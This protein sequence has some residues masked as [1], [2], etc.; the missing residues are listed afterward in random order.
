VVRRGIGDHALR[1]ADRLAAP[2]RYWPLKIGV[3]VTAAS[4]LHAIPA[5]DVVFDENGLRAKS[6]HLLSHLG[7]DGPESHAAKLDFRL[8]APALVRPFDASPV[9][10]AVLY[11]LCGVVAY[12]LMAS[13]LRRA[14]VAPSAVLLSLGAVAATA[15]GGVFLI[16]PRF[17]DGL[18]IALA[19][20]AG[21]VANR[22]FAAA[23]A[24]V[25][26]YTDERA[27]LA[28]LVCV[29]AFRWLDA[30]SD[31]PP[32][33][34]L[35]PLALLG[36][37]V[38]YAASRL[39]LDAATALRTETADVGF[40]VVTENLTRWPVALV[41]AFALAWPILVVGLALATQRDL[42]RGAVVV[43]LVGAVIAASTLVHDVTRSA[44]YALPA[45]PVAVL[46]I[47]RR[48][49]ERAVAKAFGLAFVACM[50]VPAFAMAGQIQR[51][52]PLPVQILRWFGVL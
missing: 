48:W 14:K 43:A 13:E 30:R 8:V 50:L 47:A 37:A 23:L 26:L 42:V 46:A 17:F 28:L 29:A 12:A 3:L 15:A 10:A 7:A 35:S 44:A 39:V 4:A 40:G 52:N 34:G 24:F 6:L 20:A 41:A 11:A 22:W 45:V 2:S 33:R 49:P 27:L 1:F 9:A 25:A 51:V 31:D 32:P 38:A 18:A 36:A 5:Y 19:L 16:D 21:V